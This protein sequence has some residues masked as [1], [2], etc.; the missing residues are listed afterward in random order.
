MEIVETRD[1]NTKKAYFPDK[2]FLP[3]GVKV[4]EKAGSQDVFSAP[5]SKID[6]QVLTIL[7]N[8]TN[9]T[10]IEKTSENDNYEEWKGGDMSKVEDLDIPAKGGYKDEYWEINIGDRVV[11]V[12]KPKDPVADLEEV[13][14][15]IEMGL[16]EEEKKKT[17][18]AMR[19][20]FGREEN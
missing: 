6:P 2:N 18:R 14:S 19:K 5:I 13:T 7:T 16:P 20:R 17:H 8:I 12:Q 11:R 15:D 3:V 1:L 10:E 9:I 4:R